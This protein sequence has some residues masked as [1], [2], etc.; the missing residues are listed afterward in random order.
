M[1]KAVIFDLDGTL[2]DTLP[3]LK[4][5]INEALKI[6]GYNVSYTYEETMWLIG[7]GTKMLC[8]RAINKFNPTEEEVE[9]LFI[10]FSRIYKERQLEETRL[11]KNVKKCKESIKSGRNISQYMLQ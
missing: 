3:D 10:D 7:S 5:S 9:K 4:N 11:Y 8:R 6:N 2:L 1:Y